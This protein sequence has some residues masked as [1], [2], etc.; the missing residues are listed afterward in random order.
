MGHTCSLNQEDASGGIW[1][2]EEGCCVL[3]LTCVDSLPE[4][5]CHKLLSTH[6]LELKLL[7]RGALIPKSQSWLNVLIQLTRGVFNPL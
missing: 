4:I 5:T 6:G 7:F 1:V 2:G 3:K